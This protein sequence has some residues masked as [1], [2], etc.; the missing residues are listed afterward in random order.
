[1]LLVLIQPLVIS[2]WGQL[3]TKEKFLVDLVLTGSTYKHLPLFLVCVVSVCEG[4]HMIASINCVCTFCTNYSRVN[5]DLLVWGSVYSVTEC[6]HVLYST[7][8]RYLSPV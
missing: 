5:G 1:M 6:G 2:N 7:P 8:H 4:I 3:S